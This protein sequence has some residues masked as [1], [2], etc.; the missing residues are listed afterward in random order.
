MTCTA[1]LCLSLLWGLCR[2]Q[3]PNPQTNYTRP[4]FLCGGD[5]TGDAGY[6]AS[7]G[8]PNYY[9]H[10][11]KCVWN[12]TVPEG[13][14]VTLTFRVLD[15]ESDPSCRFDS[16]SVYN[17]HSRSAQQLARVCGTF[18]PGAV[19]STG[20]TMML[21][22][23]S[24]D[25]KGG[26]GFLAWYSATAPHIS[27][28][29]FCGGKFE[30]PQGSL[31]TPNWPENNYPS[32]ISCSWH[33][34]APQ[35]QVIELS[36][37]KF[38]VEG[39]SYCRYDYVALFNGGET[40]N[41]RLI[42]KFCGDTSPK[43]IYSDANEMLV[44]FVSDLSVTADGFEAVYRMKD[45]S[46]IIKLQDSKETLTRVPEEKIHSVSKKPPSPKPIPKDTAKPTLK[47]TPKPTLKATPKP[48]Q[49]ATAKPI[50]KATAIP[51]TK[52]TAKPTRKPKEAKLAS[53]V[54]PKA[55]TTASYDSSRNPEAKTPVK[56]PEKCRKAGTLSAHYCANQF[57]VSGTVK[58]LVK[59]DEENT[60]LATV[61]IINSYKVGDL[62]VQQAGKSMTIKVVNECPRCP[63]LKRGLN[64]LFMGAV[65]DEGRG[66]ILPES[67][68]IAYKAAQ[69][70]LLTNLAN[71]PC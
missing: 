67:F 4:V 22:M 27:D 21:E 51:T 29:R 5:I 42:G 48:T 9:P 16:L 62:S 71:K 26:R 37:K 30:K 32:G 49:K 10:N 13:H 23:I 28:I 43:S 24:D 36:F 50:L 19:M 2:G 7:E 59:G 61:N 52:A 55:K 33:I 70:Q 41:N 18:R 20:N 31:T 54:E 57:V 63:I 69:H 68:V 46:E 40:D 53:T 1:L 12:I 6:I 64:Y 65:D 11:K 15:M 34:V 3:N 56:C 60:L 47:A 25:E 58:T 44:Q 66:R 14:L 39:D 8:F 38:D 35:D 17:G 45:A